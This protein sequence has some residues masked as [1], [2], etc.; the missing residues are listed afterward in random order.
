MKSKYTLHSILIDWLFQDICL[1]QRLF[2]GES[3]FAKSELIWRSVLE[4]I[5][6]LSLTLILTS[7]IKIEYAVFLSFLCVHSLNWFLNGHGFLIL[8]TLFGPVC[9]PDKRKQFIVHT[10][11]SF[12]SKDITSLVYGSISLE[13][14]ND[15]SDIDVFVI[16]CGGLLNGLKLSMIVT[17]SRL[18]AV[19]NLVPLD[20]YCIDDLEYLKRRVYVRKKERS[21]LVL[22]D[23][24][25]IIDRIIGLPT[26][27]LML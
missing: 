21:F 3:F 17:I 24:K 25:R 12:Y 7:F 8:L 9:S 26:K 5:L 15:R 20:I 16:N 13:K 18:R 4:L 1:I 10:A 2:S 22:T 19:V 6:S 14:V 23:P 11:N 27:E